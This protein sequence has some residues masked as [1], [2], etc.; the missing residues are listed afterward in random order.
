M[1]QTQFYRTSNELEHLFLNIEK[2]RPIS[3]I[4][5][6][7]RKPYFWLGTVKQRK[8][9]IPWMQGSKVEARVSR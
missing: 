6:Q 3:S 9:N 2:T 5:Y 7:T 4:G 8:S 1:G